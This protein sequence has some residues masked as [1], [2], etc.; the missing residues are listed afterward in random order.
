ML[1]F[2]K[3]FETIYNKNIRL[4]HSLDYRKGVYKT[5]I[6]NV[7][8]LVVLGAV[9]YVVAKQESKNLHKW[10]TRRMDLN[11]CFKE[12]L[13]FWKHFLKNPIRFVGMTILLVSQKS[14][15]AMLSMIAGIL[16]VSYYLIWRGVIDAFS[17]DW[18]RTKIQ[19][20]TTGAVIV[21]TMICLIVR[22]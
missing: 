3:L 4:L 2:D 10:L 22:L 16:V 19:Y 11:Y 7:I 21:I 15:L 9:F 6:T 1:I 12:F 14:V 17:F 13:D 20:I 18:R 5:M 8:T